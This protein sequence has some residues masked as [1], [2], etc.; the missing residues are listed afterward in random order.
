[1]PNTGPYSLAAQSGGRPAT[2]PAVPASCDEEVDGLELAR[3]ARSLWPRNSNRK[4][5]APGKQRPSSVV[6]PS[7]V[8]VNKVADKSASEFP[9]FRR[10]TPVVRPSHLNLRL[11]PS[12]VPADPVD[13]FGSGATQVDSPIEL[14]WDHEPGTTS[15]QVS[16]R[17]STIPTRLA[18]P[19]N[20]TTA[21]DSGFEQNDFDTLEG[22]RFTE[23]NL[24]PVRPRRHAPSF[25][26]PVAVL[27]LAGSPTQFQ[28]ACNNLATT[29]DGFSKL[30]QTKRVPSRWAN[31]EALVSETSCVNPIASTTAIPHSNLLVSPSTYL[32]DTLLNGNPQA[33]TCHE[34]VDSGFVGFSGLDHDSEAGVCRPAEFLWEHEVFES[35]RSPRLTSTPYS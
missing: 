34:L 28:K 18:E 1:L 19:T 22:R 7:N 9:Q 25:S 21:Y 26:R 31:S 24:F 4:K 14:D 5:S 2:E 29:G 3:L 27:P 6:I 33:P 8:N 20:G 13:I 15:P 12:H 32:P 23:A 10:T 11:T 17:A 30:S 35:P 16:R